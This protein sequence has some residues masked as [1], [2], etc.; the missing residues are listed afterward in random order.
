MWHLDVVA[1][2]TSVEPNTILVEASLDFLILAFGCFSN[3]LISVLK[4]LIS[5]FNFFTF[6][7]RF[8]FF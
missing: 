4:V 7:T 2:E 3:F 5:D 1:E 6:S 8:S